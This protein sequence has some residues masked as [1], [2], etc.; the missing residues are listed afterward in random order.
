MHI[1]P[2]ALIRAYGTGDLPVRVIAKT[3]VD[4]HRAM[5]VCLDEL[6]EVVGEFGDGQLLTLVFGPIVT[7]SPA[8]AH[9]FTANGLAG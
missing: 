4:R 2:P 9:L 5:H 6:A 1:V 3:G 7:R 8:Q